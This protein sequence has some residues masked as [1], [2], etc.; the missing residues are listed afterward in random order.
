MDMG[1]IFFG[2]GKT[3]KEETQEENV[4]KKRDELNF[5]EDN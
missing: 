1:K 4:A 5:Y 3:V 2:H